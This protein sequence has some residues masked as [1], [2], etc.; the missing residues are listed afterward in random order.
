MDLFILDKLIILFA[1]KLMSD[2]VT[3]FAT[4]TGLWLVSE[5]VFPKKTKKEQK[6]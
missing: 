4:L 6:K 5:I 1:K 3:Q 2:A